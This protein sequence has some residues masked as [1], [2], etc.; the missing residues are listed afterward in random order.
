MRMQWIAL[1]VALGVVACGGSFEPG[2]A[3]TWG[4]HESGLTLTTEDQVVARL[5]A[6]TGAGYGYGEYLPPGYLTSTTSYP[7]IIHL[8]GAGEFGTSPTEAHLLEFVTRHGALKNI[9]KTA[10][11]KAYFGQNQVMV[12]TPRAPTNWQPAAI[13]AFISFIVANYRVDTTRIYLT[14]ISFG[15]YGAWQ[16][17]YTYGSRLAALAPMATNIGAPGPTITQLKNVPVWAVH[18]FADG[19]SLSAETSWLMSVTKNYGLFQSVQVTSP[20]QKVTYLFPGA[21]SPV[22]TLQ[23][24]VV[25]TGSDIARLTVLPGG[26]HDCWT[27]QYDNYAFWDWLLAQHR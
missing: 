15:G 25:A 16:Y 10:Q 4:T 3:D 17:A 14:G 1:V 27:Q 6:S 2:E 5:P 18:S 24:G 23:T 8:N 11:G 7:V 12:F 20:T 13:D 19:S 22:W 9:H 26:V 21:S